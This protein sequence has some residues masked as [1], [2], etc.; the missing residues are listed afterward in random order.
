MTNDP[1]QAFESFKSS[2]KT[3]CLSTVTGENKPAAS[4]APFFE[5]DEGNFYIFVSQLASHTQDLLSNP[6]A[7]VLLMEDEAKSRQLFARQRISYQCDV[8]IIRPDDKHFNQILDAFERRQGNTVALL[9]TLS[10]FILF[11]LK[12]YEGRY[13]LGFGKAYAL[14]GER[15]SELQHID[16]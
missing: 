5:D 7:G 10:D 11:R 2:I 9:R 3:L 8:D 1:Q 14:A 13:V 15:L 6:I 16:S 4:Y 12:P